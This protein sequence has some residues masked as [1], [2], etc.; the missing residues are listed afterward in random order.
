VQT[1][2]GAKRPMRPGSAI[3]IADGQTTEVVIKILRGSVITGV[4][5]DHAN[6]PAAQTTVS[7]MRYMMQNGERRLAPAGTGGITD[8]RG[9][10]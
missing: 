10:A 9:G 4:V 7:A 1:A 6:Q 3:P 8:D 5:L 2:Y